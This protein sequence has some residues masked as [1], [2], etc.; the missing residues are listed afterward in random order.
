M[1]IEFRGDRH[2]KPNQRNFNIMFEYA[3]SYPREAEESLAAAKQRYKTLLGLVNSAAIA[4]KSLIAQMEIESKAVGQGYEYSITVPNELINLAKEK[5][6]ASLSKFDCVD[7]SFFEYLT[8]T[9]FSRTYDSEGAIAYSFPPDTQ[10][11]ISLTPSMSLRSGEA[12][13]FSM[14]GQP[15]KAFDCFLRVHRFL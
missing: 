6:I 11:N 15:A 14:Y 1:A 5:A 7:L 12:K 8:T 2:S 13:E 10:P 3:A 4:V 9:E